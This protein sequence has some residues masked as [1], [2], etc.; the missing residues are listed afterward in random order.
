MQVSWTEALRAI[1]K[2]CYKHHG[3]EDLLHVFSEDHSGPSTH[4]IPQAQ[5][6][7]GT[8]VQTINNPDGTV[9]FIQ[10]DTSPQSVVTLADGTQATVVH[11]VSLYL[12]SGSSEFHTVKHSWTHTHSFTPCTCSWCGTDRFSL[13]KCVCLSCSECWNTPGTFELKCRQEKY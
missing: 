7:A 6:F 10:I 8:M 2:N 3:R 5:A 1:V 9:S 11:A 13:C 4:H 12:T